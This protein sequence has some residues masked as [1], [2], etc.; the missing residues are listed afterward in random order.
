MRQFLAIILAALLLLSCDQRD[1]PDQGIQI[2]NDIQ[3]KTYNVIKV[4]RVRTEHGAIS[5]SRSLRPGEKVLLPRKSIASFR[6][7]RRYR[8]HTK[9]YE[10]E[11]PTRLKK[12]INIRLIDAHVNR[13]AGNCRTVRHY[14]Y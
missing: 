11:C 2:K 14:R 12:G 9:V 10:V 4:D 1:A 13:M 8:D 6:L 7:S 3:D 5:F